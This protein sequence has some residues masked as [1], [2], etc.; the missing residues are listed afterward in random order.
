MTVFN[1][2]T[3]AGS[4]SGGGAGIQ[5]DLKAIAALG[6]YGASVLTALTAQNTVGVQAVHHLP[7]E[8]VL[9][10]MR[11]LADDIRIDAIKIGMLDRAEIVAA[12][13]EGLALFPD[14]PVILDPVM[15]AKSGHKLLANDA[16]AA[17]RQLL[18][19]KARLITPNLPEAAVLLG[20]GEP[21]DAAGM[22]AMAVPLRQLGCRAVLLKGGHLP[23]PV[24][25][26][27]LIEPERIID[28]AGARID[29]ANTHG[30]G[31]TLSAAIA[32]LLPQ[33][34][35]LEQ[36]VRGAITYLRGAIAAADG[37]TVG[38]GHGPV[39]HFYR[40]FPGV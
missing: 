37:L 22:R 33:S 29:T 13:A 19:P 40:Q 9:A 28:I 7:A 15:V 17:I 6:G 5:A 27:L 20:T 31:C 21:Q 16:I 35:N 32:T 4:D 14:V 1:V 12:V 38:R 25:P 23:G 2:L 11:S 24:C 10:Q 36:A 18:V 39:H 3:V 26:D 34:A 30:T 8:F